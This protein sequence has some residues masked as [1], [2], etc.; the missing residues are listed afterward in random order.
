MLSV[1]RA[2]NFAGFQFSVS[3]RELLRVENGVTPISLASRATELLLLFLNR[4]SE[5]IT[6]NEIMDAV[7]PDLA[8]EE[9][10]LTV[11]ISALRRGRQRSGRRKLHSNRC[12]TRLQ[13]Y[14]SGQRRRRIGDVSAAWSGRRARG[15]S[16]PCVGAGV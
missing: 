5:L 9:G 4:P 14:R 10:N 12:G 7:W 11:Q 6:K 2:S 15:E 3:T 8:V 13:I 1:S 16:R